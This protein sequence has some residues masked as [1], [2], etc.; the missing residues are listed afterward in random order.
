MSL[1]NFRSRFVFTVSPRFL[2]E[3]HNICSMAKLNTQPSQN[4]ACAI[5]AHGSSLGASHIYAWPL[6]IVK[7]ANIYFCFRQW[8]GLEQQ[9]EPIPGIAISLAS[10]IKPF[11]QQFHCLIPV[12]GHQRPVICDT[13]VPVMTYKFR[14]DF[15]EQLVYGSSAVCPYPLFHPTDSGLVFFPAGLA[16]YSE[17]AVL[18]L[19]AVMGKT[20]KVELAATRETLSFPGNGIWLLHQ[21]PAAL[22]PLSS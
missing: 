8:F 2:W 17:F 19:A 10:S 7:Y 11:E 12:S 6:P 9:Q 3:C 16:F 18:A 13:I 21:L 5:H 15:L 14:F 1:F 20:K 4:R 22:F